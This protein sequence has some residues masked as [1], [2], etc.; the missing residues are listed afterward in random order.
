VKLT[1][2]FC[3]VEGYDRV[4]LC[5]MGLFNGLLPFIRMDLKKQRTPWPEIASELYR[6][7]DRRVSAKLMPTFADRGCRVVSAR[8]PIPYSR[9]SRPET[10]LFLPSSSSVVLNEAEWTPCQTHCFSENLIA[11]AIEPGTFASIARNSDH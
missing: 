7:S 3:S 11:P 9:L 6:P 8:I 4:E 5:L 2:H 1:M 10:S